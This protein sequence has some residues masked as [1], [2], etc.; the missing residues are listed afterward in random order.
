VFYD[1][2]IEVE[3]VFAEQPRVKVPIDYAVRREGEAKVLISGRVTL[4]FIDRQRQRPVA[5]PERVLA[6]FRE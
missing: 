4:C 2:V 3:T 6:A 5:A 1:D